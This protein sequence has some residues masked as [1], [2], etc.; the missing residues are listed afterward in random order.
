[1]NPLK[2][3]PALTTKNGG[4]LEEKKKRLWKAAKDFE[5]LLV[6]QMIR[7]MRATLNTKESLLYG[8]NAEDIFQ[9]MLDREYSSLISS[10]TNLGLAIQIYNQMSK[11]VR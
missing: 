6:Y 3:D 9:E 2:L 11:Y 8:G 10:N 1:M 7:A 4:P 5:A